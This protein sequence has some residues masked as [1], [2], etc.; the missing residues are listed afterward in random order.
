EDHEDEDHE[1]HDH[2]EAGHSHGFAGGGGIY[3]FEKAFLDDGFFFGRIETKIDASFART[4]GFSI[5]AGENGYGRTTWIAGA[6]LRGGTE[7]ADRPVWWQ[8][9]IFY[10]E[11]Q[12]RD[13][14]GNRGE[15]DE[16]GIYAACGCEFAKDWTAGSRVEWA[17]GDRDAGNERRWRASANVGRVIHLADKADLHTRLQYSYDR[18][19]G[20]GDEHSV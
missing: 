1:D 7:L 13:F 17:S 19:G 2:D 15:Y 4:A 10:R 8:G 20:Y 9:E 5:A 11:V 3:D 16:F 6:D 12:A 14:A 18:L